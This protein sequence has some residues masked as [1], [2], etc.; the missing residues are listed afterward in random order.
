M[1]ENNNDLLDMAQPK[2]KSGNPKGRPK[3]KPNKVTSTIKEWIVGLINDNRKDVE[4]AFSNLKPKEKIVM[5]EK[6][7]PYVVPKQQAITGDIQTSIKQEEVAELD[8]SQ[9]PDDLLGQVIDCIQKK[10]ESSEKKPN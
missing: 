4:E 8:L 7:L 6:L 9:I 5:L 10:K 3:G 1:I 2:G